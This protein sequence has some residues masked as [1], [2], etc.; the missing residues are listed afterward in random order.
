MKRPLLV[1]G[2]VLAASPASAW[3]K[4]EGGSMARPVETNSN[5]EALF[6]HCLDGP[7]ID[8]YAKDGAPVLPAHGG[9]EADYFY[10]PGAVRADVDGTAFPLVAAGSDIAVVLF[11]EG[12]AAQNYMAPVDVALFD[13]MFA[14]KTLTI[15]FDITP[16]AA[17]DGSPHETFIRFDLAGAGPFINDAIDP[18]R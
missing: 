18:C 3:E 7:A 13:A 1:L 9:G 14:G 5:V 12:E 16:A 8:L 4:A 17:A 2:L 10:K 11:S 15:G 6:V